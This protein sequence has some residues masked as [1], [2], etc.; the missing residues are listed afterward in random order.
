MTQTT[1][2]TVKQITQSEDIYIK[3]NSFNKLINLASSKIAQYVEK[4]FKNKQILFVCGP[5]NNG[6]DGKLAFKKI[7]NKSKLSLLELNKR[8]KFDNKKLKKLTDS[9]EIIFDCIFGVGLNREV[10]G[11][12]KLAINLINDSKK[13]VISIDIPSGIDSDSGRI[14]GVCIKA[15]KTLA[16]NFLKPCYFLLPSKEFAGEIE[17]LDLGLDYPKK[18]APNISLISRK[19]FENKIPKHGLNIN[20]Y[21]KGN[22]LIL[23]GSMSGASRLV[24]YSARKTGC[25]LSTIVLDE[26]NLKYYLKSEPGTIIKIFHKTDFDKKDVLVIGPGLGKDYNKNKV[27]EFIKCFTGPIILDAD[28]LSIFE[29]FRNDLISLLKKKEKIL[30][31]PH[32]GEFKRLFDYSDQSKITS[33]IKASNLIQ[34]YVLL[35]GNDTVISFPKNKVWINSLDKNNLATAGSGDLLCGIIAGLIAQKMDF[36]SAILASMWIQSRISI[37][38]NHVTVEDFL[39]QIPIVINSLKNNN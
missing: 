38:K 12:Y 15:N 2:L 30:L 34:N 21:D 9:S 5:G 31:T 24:A 13:K 33:C 14:M 28:A 1:L 35:K 36:S 29:N 11:S 23:G 32:I 22:V 7:K 4:N 37:S 17:L 20:K 26:F 18:L 39:D 8:K 25:G 16:M 3:K 10:L 6:V 27:L 19:I